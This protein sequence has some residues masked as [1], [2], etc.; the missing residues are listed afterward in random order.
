MHKNKSKKKL[1]SQNIVTTRQKKNKKEL[2]LSL[3][4]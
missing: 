2:K 1:E 4:T 3:K